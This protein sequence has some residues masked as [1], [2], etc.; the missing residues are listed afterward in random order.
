MINVHESRQRRLLLNPYFSKRTIE[1]LSPRLNKT[2]S[3]L[4]ARLDEFATAGN[5]LNLQK[6]FHCFT[7]DFITEYAFGK[8]ANMLEDPDFESAYVRAVQASAKTQWI[9][10]HFPWTRK[11]AIAVPFL[12]RNLDR[13]LADL[14]IV[15]YSYMELLF[16]F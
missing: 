13:G 6:A 7:V 16:I 12:F 1:S 3:K 4:S 10:K 11:L 5:P 15:S 14:R 9:A 2:I 8:C